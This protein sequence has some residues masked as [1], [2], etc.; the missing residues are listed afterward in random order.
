MCHCP[1]QKTIIRGGDILMYGIKITCGKVKELPLFARFQ[2]IVFQH[3]LGYYLVLSCYTRPCLAPKVSLDAL[4]CRNSMP[5]GR[6]SSNSSS[7]EP[8]CC[9][10]P[11]HRQRE[12]TCQRIQRRTSKRELKVQELYAPECDT[13]SLH[14]GALFM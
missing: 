8:S 7:Q 4:F 11:P 12:R 9:R 1:L 13:H 3:L 2:P 14:N 6:S 5:Y 10:I